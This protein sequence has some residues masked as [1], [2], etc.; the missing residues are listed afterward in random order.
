MKIT[1]ISFDELEFDENWKEWTEGRNEKD[2]ID[3]KFYSRYF[4]ASGEKGQFVVT[5]RNEKRESYTLK[6]GSR[7]TVEGTRL[8]FNNECKIYFR[9]IRTR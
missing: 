3:P 6:K 4:E 2:A 5:L 7:V 1:F 8:H 9:T